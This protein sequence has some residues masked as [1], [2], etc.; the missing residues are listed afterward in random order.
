MFNIN[1]Q[2][3]LAQIAGTVVG[4]ARNA[5]A[6]IMSQ[7]IYL[8]IGGGRGGQP[9]FV[10]DF[11][12]ALIADP[13]AM[14]LQDVNDYLLSSDNG[15][16][17][18]LNYISKAQASGSNPAC[19][20]L[21][22]NAVPGDPS[23]SL[24]G[25]K[26]TMSDGTNGLC[27]AQLKNSSVAGVSTTGNGIS[28]SNITYLNNN[29]NWQ[30][31]PGGT[32]QYAMVDSTT[33][34]LTQEGITLPTVTASSIND[35]ARIYLSANNN[36]Q[37]DVYNASGTPLSL[38]STL[39]AGG[40]ANYPIA[41]GACAANILQQSLIENQDIIRTKTIANQGYI[42]L[43]DDN[44][45][46]KTPGISLKGLVD[47]ASNIPTTIVAAGK[48]LAEFAAGAVGSL[49][50]GLINSLINQGIAQTTNAINEGLG[51]ATGGM[52]GISSGRVG[53]KYLP[54]ANTTPVNVQNSYIQSHQPLT[55]PST[56][57]PTTHSGDWQIN[58]IYIR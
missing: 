48:N 38:L 34:W 56:N 37:V 36:C 39:T 57:T 31:V 41:R 21:S 11:R 35:G 40:R 14:A 19:W 27:F 53:N 15:R 9:L 46:I 5:A 30:I 8:Q 47:A 58:P 55:K 49:A 28:S 45:N 26:C 52:V 43:T 17:S 18:Q 3:I 16:G 4:A 51:N 22:D 1:Y 10:T 23:Y 32:T 24:T 25:A 12:T 20:C 50:T 42:S 2:E 44:G 7:Q 6:Q 54:N 29:P 33:N 13:S